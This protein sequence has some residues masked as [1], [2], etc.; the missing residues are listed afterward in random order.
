[1]P[2]SEPPKPATIAGKAAQPV[3]MGLPLR[4]VLMTAGLALLAGFFMPWVHISG[5][6]AVSGLGLM[7]SQ[8]EAVEMIAGAH[9]F[10]LF[11]VPVFGVLL[12][13]A[14][15]TAHRAGRWVALV[16]G[17]TVIG[18]GLLTLIMMFFRT[19]GA[20]MWVVIFGALAALCA[21]LLTL[22]RSR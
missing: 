22:Q 7:G 17:V 5:V 4:A 8:G 15:V 6:A 16:A 10:L 1:M 2:T 3:T 9:R 18:G 13:A 14:A 12:I 21:G 19:T 20:G 11:A